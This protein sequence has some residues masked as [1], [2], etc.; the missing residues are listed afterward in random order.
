MELDGA[1]DEML[2]ASAPPVLRRVVEKRERERERAQKEGRRRNERE[3]RKCTP[4]RGCESE[5]REGWPADRGQG[6]GNCANN[7]ATLQR[8]GPLLAL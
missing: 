8:Y 3:K 7:H 2:T 1:S 4:E 5:R 6:V